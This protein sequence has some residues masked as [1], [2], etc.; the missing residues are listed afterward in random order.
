VLRAPML[1]RVFAVE[2]EVLDAPDGAP[3]VIPRRAARAHDTT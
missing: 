1:A 3:L 2:A